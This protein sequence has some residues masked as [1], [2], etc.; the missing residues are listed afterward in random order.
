MKDGI[1]VWFHDGWHDIIEYYK[2][3]AR[4][5]LVF[6]YENN[7]NFLVLVFNLSACEILYPCNCEEPGNYQQNSVHQPEMESSTGA[8]R[9]G[10]GKARG[11][12][13][14]GQ[15]IEVNIY[16]GRIVTPVAVTEISIVFYQNITGPWIKYKEYPEVGH[17]ALFARFKQIQRF[18]YTCIEEDLNA[19]F[20]KTV[21]NLYGN[22]MH[23]L[24]KPI[25]EKYKSPKER[26]AHPP[27]NVSPVV[28]KEMVDKWMDAKW[29]NKS[30]KSS[31]SQK[32]VQMY[33]TTGSVSFATDKY[34][35]VKQTGVE[36]SP[37]DCFKK[38]NMSKTKDGEAKWSSMK[39]EDVYGPGGSR[40]RA[41]VGATLEVK[42]KSMKE[43]LQQ[44][45]AI[46]EEMKKMC[47]LMKAWS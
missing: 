3:T 12:A 23:R 2:I 25:F 5:V 33:H 31:N 39:P 21:S 36:P 1:K 41:R 46:Q 38:F 45:K 17:E 35:Q 43:E 44:F 14:R 22:W 18:R 20:L 10:R 11:V 8:K 4:Y 13:Y 27:D 19:A 16:Q 40:K 24:R 34:E 26:I 42:I 7:S 6:K 29:Q 15:D 9:K 28:W 32:S 47:E 37:I 30:K